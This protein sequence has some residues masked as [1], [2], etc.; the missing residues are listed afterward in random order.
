M[1]KTKAQLETEIKELRLELENQSK[2]DEYLKMA[3]NVYDV[4]LS[5]TAVGFTE[6]QAWEIIKLQI[7]KGGQ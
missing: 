5:F 7:L 4:Y 3:Q 2:N 1:N 6:A